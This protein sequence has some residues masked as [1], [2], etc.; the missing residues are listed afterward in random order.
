MTAVPPIGSADFSILDAINSA[1]IWAG[2]FR[3]PAS[4]AP[5]RTFLAALFALP[6]GEADL[7][8]FRECTGRTAP[9]TTGFLETWLVCGRRA[10]KSFILALIACF[11]AV[12]RDWRPYLSPGEVGTVKIIATDRKQ[13]RVIHRYCRALLTKVPAFASLIAQDTDDEIALTNGVVIEVQTASFRSARGYTCIAALCDEIAFWRSDETAANPDAEILRALRP[14]MATIPNAMLLCASSPYAKRGELYNAHRR[15]FGQDD[16]PVLVWQAPTRLMN[17]T[18][19]QSVIDEA[20]ERDPASAAAEYGAEFRSDIETFLDRDLV[21]AA[22]DRGVTVRRP[23]DGVRYVLFIDPSG[24]RGDSFT[25]AIGHRD[26]NSLLIDAAYE[27]RA[28]FVSDGAV[29]EVAALAR[30]YGVSVG[31]GDA[32]G[33]DLVVSAFRR[34]GITYRPLQIHGDAAKLNRTQIYLNALALFTSGRARLLDSPRLIHQLTALE[35]RTARS[36]HDTID[37]PRS[38]A[39]DLAN[40]V[41]GC[42]VALAAKASAASLALPPDQLRKLAAMPPRD[43]FSRSAGMTNF[44]SRQLR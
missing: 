37:H 14:A 17:P 44:P 11:L 36:G 40:A 32:Y 38:G 24:G 34:R 41:C 29:D 22:I 15:Y 39:D 25:A 21:E 12:F 30:S 18:V 28:P 13:A 23:I 42:L 16:A 2:W 4:W 1:A 9:P 33:A 5:W 6:M 43:R 35:R 3:R 19:P 10:G 27:K 7:A 20:T 26:G 8:L 31:F